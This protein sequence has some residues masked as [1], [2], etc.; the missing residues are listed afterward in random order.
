MWDK[1]WFLTNK[2]ILG[3]NTILVSTFWGYSKFDPYILVIIN[4]VS[5]I[6]HLQSN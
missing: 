1:M 4:L 3:E 6:F 2:F 5:I